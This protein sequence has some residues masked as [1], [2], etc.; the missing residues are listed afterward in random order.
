M[1]AAKPFILF[2]AIGLI[3]AFVSYSLPDLDSNWWTGTFL[4]LA[5]LSGANALY[6]EYREKKRLRSE[7]SQEA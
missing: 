4:L 6:E 5:L 7:T 3:A 2:Y 1:Q